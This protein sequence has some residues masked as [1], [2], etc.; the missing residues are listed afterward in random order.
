MNF[1]KRWFGKKEVIVNFSDLPEWLVSN[2]EISFDTELNNIKGSFV[3]FDTAIKNLNELDITS[4]P[5]VDIRLANR[6]KGNKKAYVHALQI[7]YNQLEIPIAFDSNSLKKYYKAFQES[8]SAFNKKTIKN[9][10]ILKTVVGQELEDVIVSIK[11]ISNSVSKLEKARTDY[12]LEAL[13][14]IHSRIQEINDTLLANNNVASRLQHAHK[15]RG[16]LIQEEANLLKDVEKLR[17]C[18]EYKH[19]DQLKLDMDATVK[20]RADLRSELL[21]KIIPLERAFKKYSKISTKNKSIDKFLKEKEAFVLK[22]SKSAESLIFDLEQAINKHSIDIKDPKK[23]LI[24]I[25]TLKE[26]L[27]VYVKKITDLKKKIDLIQKKIATNQ[28]EKKLQEYLTSINKVTKKLTKL[29]DEE[30]NLE[31]RD[32][33]NDVLYI[34]KT[35]KK[36]GYSIVIKHD[37]LD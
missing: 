3:S 31:K 11:R 8:A 1:I 35:L 24:S 4:I 5:N 28:Y 34:E 12:N 6:L 21:G 37:T 27:K 29:L 10:H 25:K 22:D 16:V 18:K 23:I 9:Y 15:E 19:F 13:E 20:E 33:K 7:F 30:N 36:M 2:I 26:F 14:G 17:N 32:L